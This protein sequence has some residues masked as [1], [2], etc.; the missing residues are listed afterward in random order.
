MRG[1]PWIRFSI[2]AAVL[3]VVAIPL[4]MLTSDDDS[5]APAP[6][7][8]RLPSG[9]REVTLEIET[10]PSAQAIG[11]SYLGQQLIPAIQSG[12]SFSGIIRLPA[13]TGADLVVTATWAGTNASAMRVRALDET[14]L[15][16]EASFWGAQ[17]VQDVFTV[18]EVP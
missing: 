3:A 18:P 8:V 15:L 7:E 10:A 16:A 12:G 1:T 4:W 2:M 13:G 5:T 11:V 6:P 14:G 9:E 17:K